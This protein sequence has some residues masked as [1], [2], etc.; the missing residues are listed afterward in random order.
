MLRFI[1]KDNFFVFLDTLLHLSKEPMNTLLQKIKS[2]NMKF[3]PSLTVKNNVL[4]EKNY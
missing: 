1:T 4:V 2:K 3:F